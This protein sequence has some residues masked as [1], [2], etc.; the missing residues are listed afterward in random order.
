MS[1]G[2]KQRPIEN[3]EAFESN[4]DKIFKKEKENERQES[5]TEELQPLRTTG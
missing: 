4:W 2:S 3:R 5:T 1:K